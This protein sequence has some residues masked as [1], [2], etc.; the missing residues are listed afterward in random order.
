MEVYW[1]FV[2]FTFSVTDI[3]GPELALPVTSGYNEFAVFVPGSYFELTKFS[4][5]KI[6]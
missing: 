2:V 1:K 6:V 3:G 4:P 5:H